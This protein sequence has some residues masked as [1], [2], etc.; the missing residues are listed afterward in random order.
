MSS[1]HPYGVEFIGGPFDGYKHVVSFPPD[2]LA[3]LVVLPVNK[4]VL[5]SLD[6]QPLGQKQPATSAVVYE[7]CEPQGVFRYRFR[8]TS[9]VHSHM[10]DRWVG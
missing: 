10:L 4:N 7:L 6:G 2:H 9:A 3:P 8:G 1:M 5:K